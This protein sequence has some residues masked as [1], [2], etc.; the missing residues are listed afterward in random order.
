VAS[1]GDAGARLGMLIVETIAKIRR[2]YFVQNKP[3]KVICRELRAR[4]ERNRQMRLADPGR[5]NSSKASPCPTQRQ[6]ANS[7]IKRGL[8]G[9]VKAVE[10][11]H[12]REL[13]D[14]A[15][16]L[17]AP[18][19]LAGNLALDQKGQRL[20]QGQLA[21]GRLVQQ[22]VELVTDRC[23]LEPASS[24][25][26]ILNPRE[27]LNTDADLSQGILG[28]HDKA[29]APYLFV[30]ALGRWLPLMI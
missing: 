13:G 29:D 30:N 10:V 27:V 25:I 1:V 22:T 20:V 7:R 8:G 5:A 12:H 11:A 16:H 19:V 23:Q 6:A 15:R 9:E 28:Y 4:A 21:L 26:V 24:C 14:L 17:D 18:L 2:A 3:I